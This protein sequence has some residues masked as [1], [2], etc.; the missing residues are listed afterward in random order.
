MV[1]M[2]AK[3]SQAKPSHRLNMHD[4]VSNQLDQ[5]QFMQAESFVW[6]CNF[7]RYL[8]RFE[9]MVRSRAGIVK[10]MWKGLSAHQFNIQ[11]DHALHGL[12]RLHVLTPVLSSCCLAIEHSQHGAALPSPSPPRTF[13]NLRVLHLSSCLPLVFQSPC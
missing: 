1:T 10:D 9:L 7:V 5:K 13:H 11:A 12:S 6:L 8:G 3:P 2:L 4:N